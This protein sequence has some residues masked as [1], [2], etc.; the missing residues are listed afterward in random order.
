MSHK[1]YSYQP[2]AGHGLPHES[3]ERHYRAAPDRLD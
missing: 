1:R 2:R 3:A